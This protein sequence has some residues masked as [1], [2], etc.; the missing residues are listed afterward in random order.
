M[1]LLIDRGEES[2]SMTQAATTCN[3]NIN[4]TTSLF[5]SSVNRSLMYFIKSH[6]YW[7]KTKVKSE[8]I[9]G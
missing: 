7:A 5:F 9:K 1:K 2:E 4:Q 3:F 8:E 6:I